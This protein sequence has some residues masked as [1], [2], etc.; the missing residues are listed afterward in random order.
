M[1]TFTRTLIP[2]SCVL[3]LVT[4]LALPAGAATLTVTRFD[5]PNPDGCFPADCSLRESIMLANA[6]P[7]LDTVVLAA[8]T[9]Q[10]TRPG[11]GEDANLTGDLDSTG[12][13]EIVGAGRSQTT[14]LGVGLGD[15]LLQAGSDLALRDLTSVRSRSAPPTR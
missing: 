5:D 15:R 12:P 4:A 13:L 11:A 6:Q 9:Y 7:G 1:S 10:L 2:C 14:I 3:A 8:G